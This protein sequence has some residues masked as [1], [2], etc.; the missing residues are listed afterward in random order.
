VVH[1]PTG[2]DSL[3]SLKVT[4]NPPAQLDSIVSR[5][6]AEQDANGG[7][8]ADVDFVF[9]VAPKLAESICGFMLGEGDLDAIRFSNLKPIGSPEPSEKRGF[10]ARLFGG[11]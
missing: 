6:K 11:G 9:D 4:G 8:E 2:D 10:F 7:E 5:I 3:Y 1:D